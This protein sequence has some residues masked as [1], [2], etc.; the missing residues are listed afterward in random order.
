MV[1]APGEN[2]RRFCGGASARRAPIGIS[3][4]V[5][6]A[7]GPVDGDFDFVFLFRTYRE[8]KRLGT[9]K[10]KT[11]SR[12]TSP[13][14]VIALTRNRF[15]FLACASCTYRTA[16]SPK[17]VFVRRAMRAIM[18]EKTKEVTATKCGTGSRAE[19]Q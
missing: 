10:T 12:P 6:R 7:A 1:R 15:G 9:E 4:S 11:Q 14:R 19:T 8:I 16:K 18:M 13:L 3:H 17:C 5:S 2:G